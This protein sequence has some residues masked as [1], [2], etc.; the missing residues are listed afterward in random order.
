[1]GGKANIAPKIV[2]AILGYTPRREDYH[3]PFLGGANVFA[4]LAPHFNNIYASDLHPD[5]I[6]LYRAIVDGWCPPDN[7]SRELWYELKES[8]PS[9]LRGFVG[10]NY[11]F[12]GRFFS[13]YSPN[14]GAHDFSR[15]AKNFFN[16][17]RPLFQRAIIQN[18]PYTHCVPKSSSVVYCDPP[19]KNVHG[20]GET[21]D[22][23]HFW[24][25]MQAWSIF[26]VHVFVSEYQAPAGWFPI[27]ELSKYC[28]MSA[29]VNKR[30][31]RTEKLFVWKG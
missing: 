14:K 24:K 18:N 4:K 19:Y 17:T 29:D 22:H 3:E 20:Y 27:W 16:K 8:S 23:G 11:S 9:A 1:M 6:L 21:F 7:V 28:G 15:A 25:I 12:G 10:F 5:V 2:E 13:S 31:R 30:V 26:G